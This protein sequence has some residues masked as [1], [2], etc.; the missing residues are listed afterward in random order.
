LFRRFVDGLL[1]RCIDDNA[2]QKILNEIH[3]S[4]SIVHIGGHFATKVTA[5]K[6]IRTGYYWPSIF[7]YSYEF[8]RACD[9]F[10][11]F[12]GREHFSAM[13]LQ[14]VLPDFPFYKCNIFSQFGHPLGIISYNIPT[15]IYAKL[16]QFLSV[17]IL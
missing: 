1:L 6:I 7:R 13:P 5:F 15:F 8:T 9:K 16:T 10:Q 14:H 2:T 4:T 3:E 17:R 12:V 11:K